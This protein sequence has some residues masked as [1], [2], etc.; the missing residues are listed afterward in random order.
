[1]KEIFIIRLKLQKN[2]EINQTG[3]F[4]NKGSLEITSSV[5]SNLAKYD[6]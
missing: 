5:P 4:L 2:D 3:P 1:M 6:L